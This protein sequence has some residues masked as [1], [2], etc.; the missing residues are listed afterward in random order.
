MTSFIN[1]S[2]K[3][4]TPLFRTKTTFVCLVITKRIWQIMFKI[5]WFSCLS[6]K[7]R[8]LFPCKQS[9][10]NMFEVMTFSCLSLSVRLLFAVFLLT[11]LYT[12][13]NCNTLL[14]L[15][16]RRVA[17]LWG[18][19]F[20]LSI[21]IRRW[22]VRQIQALRPIF[23]HIKMTAI[24]QLH[25]CLEG[26]HYVMWDITLLLKKR[27]F[28]CRKFHEMLNLLTL[29]QQVEQWNAHALCRAYACSMFLLGM[30]ASVTFAPCYIC[31][32]SPLL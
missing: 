18:S 28:G 14:H 32:R 7:I 17:M 23:K 22:N 10:V 4:Y 19:F 3:N 6:L 29:K 24:S 31:P 1:L 13:G 5:I 30:G 2:Q 15:P 9:I 16:L 8:L 25:I 11:S 21:G 12:R 20:Y 26:K 27:F